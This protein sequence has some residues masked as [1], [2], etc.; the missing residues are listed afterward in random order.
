MII[1]F[2]DM[3]PLNHPEWFRPGE[4]V[5]HRSRLT[6]ALQ[7]ADAISVPAA[8]IKDE[9][10]RFAAAAGLPPRRID[11]VDL[12]VARR[13]ETVAPAS[14]GGIPYFLINSTIEPRKNHAVLLEAWRRM[15]RQAPKLIIAGRRGWRNEAVFRAL[16]A[17]PANILE[18]PDVTS[19][20]LA[21][22]TRG[23]TALLSPSLAEGY[24]LPVAEAISAGTPVIA[25]DIPVYRSLWGRHARLIDPHDPDA[26]AEAVLAPPA[27][28]APYTRTDWLTYV[29]ALTVLAGS[30]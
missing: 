5:L 10:E 19:S 2:H 27:R 22:L 15:G 24:G 16:D 9:V 12:P 23:A 25:S 21:R 29:S 20:A 8:P 18:L 26:W 6:T 3:I 1:A 30:I 14:F 11:I 4:D 7:I 17:G 13:F 28:P